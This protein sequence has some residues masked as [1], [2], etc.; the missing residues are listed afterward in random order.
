MQQTQWV[1]I[2]GEDGSSATSDIVELRQGVSQ[3]SVC[4]PMIFIL[5][6][7]PLGDMSRKHKVNFHSYG[8]DQQNYLSFRPTDKTAKQNQQKDYIDVLQI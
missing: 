1:I 3:G 8:D 5:Y 2:Q 7:L 6:I 4:G